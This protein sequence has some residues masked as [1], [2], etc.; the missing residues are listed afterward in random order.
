MRS[1]LEVLR[2]A[3]VGG[4][5]S[6][7]LRSGK[8]EKRIVLP[9]VQCTKKRKKNKPKHKQRTTKNNKE[10]QRKTK[11]NNEKQ[12]KN[13]EKTK[14]NKEK[15]R[16]NKNNKEKQL[17]KAQTP[18]PKPNPQTP[19]PSTN[20]EKQRKTKK[21]IEKTKKNNEKQRKT[22]TNK[23]NQRKTKNN[24]EK[25]RKPNPKTQCPE[26][27]APSQPLSNTKPGCGQA[28]AAVLLW[29]TKLLWESCGKL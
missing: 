16:K 1:S 23:E 25:Q 5:K 28:A 18:N 19:N 7:S 14:N 2:A 27:Q 26:L 3:G 10:K 20:K 24:K 21:T 17:P 13:K 6:T 11:N 15:Q 12:R 8:R 4:Y 29:K 22:T 9:Q